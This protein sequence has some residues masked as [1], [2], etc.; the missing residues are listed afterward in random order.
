MK[1]VV[2]KGLALVA[3]T[4]LVLFA[5]YQA[6]GVIVWLMDQNLWLIKQ[7]CALLPKPYNSMAE[8]ALRGALGADKALLFAEGTWMVG[9]L[10]RVIVNRITRWWDKPSA[11][12]VLPD[13]PRKGI[14]A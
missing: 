11:L 2:I 1:S 9:G 14:A 4:A 8:S 13:R 10:L 12:R 3:G 5:W 7:G 6:S